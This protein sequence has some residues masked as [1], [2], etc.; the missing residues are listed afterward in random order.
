MFFFGKN[1][2]GLSQGRCKCH[3]IILVK[4]CSI[5]WEKKLTFLPEDDSN[6]KHTRRNFYLVMKQSDNETVSEKTCYSCMIIML[7]LPTTQNL[8]YPSWISHKIRNG[9]L[10]SLVG[11]GKLLICSLV[12]WHWNNVY[13]VSPLS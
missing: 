13:F 3:G 7:I 6:F 5:C 12:V 1:E 2:N 11:W 4:Y 9:V 10:R 8:I